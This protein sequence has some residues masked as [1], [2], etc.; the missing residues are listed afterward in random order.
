MLNGGNN[1]TF[2]PQF[3]QN[4]LC[5]STPTK[6]GIYIKTVI[7]NCQTCNRFIK[8]GILNKLGGEGRIIAFD[9]DITAIDYAKKNFNDGRLEVVHSAFSDMHAL[10]NERNLFF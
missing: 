3:V 4:T 1:P 2:A 7:F 5:M 8:Q 9:Q 10:L 6:S